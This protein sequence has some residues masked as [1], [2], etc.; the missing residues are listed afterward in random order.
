MIRP[1]VAALAAALALAAAPAAAQD[2]PPPVMPEGYTIETVA[3]PEGARFEVAGLDVNAAGDIAVSTRIGDIWILPA[4]SA[5]GPAEKAQ[6]HQFGEGLGEPLGVLWE[7]DGSILSA[8]KP[9]LSRLKDEDGDGVAELYENVANGF[10]FNDNYH[11]FHYG[12]VRDSHGNLYGS[13]NLA[14]GMKNRAYSWRGET[15]MTA[16]GQYRGWVYQVT[17][18]GEFVPFAPGFRSPAGISMSPDDQ[19]FVTDNQGDWVA[20]STFHHVKKGGFYG[21]PAGLIDLPEYDAE[22][23]DALDP[24]DFWAMAQKPAV[25]LP[26]DEVSRSPGNPVWDLSEGK[27]GP[28]AGQIFVP[29]YTKSRVFRVLL[30][31]VAGEYQGAAIVFMDGFQSGNIRAA[32]DQAG[33]MWIGQTSRGWPTKGTAPFGVQR[34]VWDGVTVPFELHT[35]ALTKTGFDLT[36]TKPLD[37]AAFEA[38]ALGASQWHYNYWS[39][40]G[41]PKVDEADLP[42]RKATLS[43]DGRTVSLTMDLTPGKVV[44]IDFAALRSAEGKAPG[45]GQVYYTLNALKE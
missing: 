41:S 13:L 22:K 6:W 45:A 15:K 33:R 40:Y 43:K 39:T 17:P 19:L 18:D 30:E 25:W 3:T 2:E 7:P 27:F 23:L 29:E 24:E 9:E 42:I 28:F 31:K 8:H 5:A 16:G 34:V 12:P 35:I 37:R 11:E 44:A 20:T 38:A 26:H 10:S 14:S 21:H 4:E 36:F 32:F 1:A